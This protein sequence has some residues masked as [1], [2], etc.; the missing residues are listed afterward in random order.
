MTRSLV[1]LIACASLA[2]TPALA[3]SLAHA[4]TLSEQTA[5]AGPGPSRFISV[6][7]FLP[8]FGYFSGE[9]EQRIKDNVAFALSG[10]HTRFD[11]RYTNIDAKLR[12]YPNDKAL[13]GFAMASSLG[14]AWIKRDQDDFDCP[15]DPCTPT[16]F[17]TFATPSFAIELSYQWLLGRSRSTSITTGFGAKRYLGGS[18]T[19]FSGI[20]RVLP[21]ARLSIGYGF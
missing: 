18:R 15:F 21:T 12:L 17:K 10:S 13:E 11:D 7:P 4:Q 9:Y 3:P 20:E 1:R 6:N 8:L 14:M 16:V 2:V 19:D 5:S